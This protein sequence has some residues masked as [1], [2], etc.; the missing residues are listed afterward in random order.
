MNQLNE[1]KNLNPNNPLK[2]LNQLNNDENQID[3]TKNNIINENK[4]ESFNELDQLKM[5]YQ[6]GLV[7][8]QNIQINQ[9]NQNVTVLT[10]KAYSIKYTQ[11]SILADASKYIYVDDP[12][13]IIGNCDN[14]MVI[15]PTTYL[16]MASGCI[17]ENEYDI[18]LDSPQGLVY[19]FYFKE[20]SNFCCRNC[21]R[22][23]TRS[24]DMYANH[25]LSGKEIEHRRNNHYFKIKRE[26]GCNDYICFCNCCRPKMLISYAKT[27]QYLGKIIDSCS[28]CYKDLEIFDANDNLIY[29]IKTHCCQI[30]LCFGRNAETVAKIDFKI[31]NPENKEIIGH[32]IKI[33]SLNDKIGRSI[34]DSH[35]GFHDASNSF[36]VNF[37]DGASP[38]QKFLLII[39]AI[40]LGYQFFI[41]NKSEC[42]DR[43]NSFCCNCCNCFTIPFRFLCGSICCCPFCCFC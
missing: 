14:A 42:Y 2:A 30:G 38:D 3:S 34:V 11:Y 10:D 33:P 4:T 5:P 17:T 32:I 8:N 19:A 35:Q 41:Q 20:K 1:L 21:C 6:L 29:E 12:I 16:Q 18:I 40:K 13:N 31:V 26:S 43:C 39:A 23:A 25:V 22:Q 37:P 28:C 24:F 15:Q 9:P 7:N 27:E 36:I